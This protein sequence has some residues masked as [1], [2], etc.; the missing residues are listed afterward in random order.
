MSNRDEAPTRVRRG[1]LRFGAMRTPVSRR[2]GSS[3]WTP[4]VTQARRKRA[5]GSRSRSFCGRRLSRLVA[6]DLFF[7][8]IDAPFERSEGQL[9][10]MKVFTWTMLGLG[11]PLLQP[12]KL[13]SGILELL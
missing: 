10:H 4:G 12:T 3:S 13:G 2:L 9:A 8:Q 5:Q 11:I 1:Y 7:H 6:C